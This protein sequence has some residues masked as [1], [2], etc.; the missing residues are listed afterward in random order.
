MG[1]VNAE[2]KK[3]Y[4]EK[5]KVYK[6]QIE[7]ILQRE[8]S[9]LAVVDK[10]DTTQAYKLITLCEDRLNLA[11]HYL[12]LNRISLSM[13]GIKNEAFLNDA[14]KSCYES[15]IHLERIVSDAVD[16]P[17]T[18]MEEYWALIDE[19]SDRK[20]YE[21]LMKLGFTI[22]S[23]IEGFGENT[24]WKW[25]FVDL[26]GRYAAVF[27]NMINFK[28]IVAGLDPR[29]EDY[30]IR[31]KLLEQAKSQLVKSADEFRLKY[32]LS[33]SRIDDF[34]TAIKFLSALRRIHLV[35]GESEGAEDV[36]RKME[37]WKQKME[38]DDRK[39]A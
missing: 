35:L 28:T 23:V 15:I 34:K 38:D 29:M 5:V 10:S 1:K 30:Q 25:S 17:F 20:R 9:L 24:K 19:L 26:N 16:A 7:Q 36:K 18:D 12:L 31:Y 21:I 13:L 37:L 4:A 3:T 6:Q 33:T 39:Q 2:A 14:R 22:E 27:K 11:A 32:E 8:K